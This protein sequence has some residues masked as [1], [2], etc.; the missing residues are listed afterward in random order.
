MSPADILALLPLLLI[1]ATSIVVMLAIAFKRNHAL[2]AG[3][4]LV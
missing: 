4:T 1:G 3:L 2:A